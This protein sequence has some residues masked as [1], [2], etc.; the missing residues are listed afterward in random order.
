M[1]EN[2]QQDIDPIDRWWRLV[3]RSLGIPD[4]M[5][6]RSARA[7]IVGQLA[8]EFEGGELPD[9]EAARVAAEA[10]LDGVLELGAAGKLDDC[11]VDDGAMRHGLLQVDV[12][13]SSFGDRVNLARGSSDTRVRAARAVDNLV[14]QI[15]EYAKNNPADT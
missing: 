6:D 8:Q 13:G 9:I 3:R 4:V 14:R 15:G 2:D 7:A 5:T 12:G 10:L 1:T 11:F